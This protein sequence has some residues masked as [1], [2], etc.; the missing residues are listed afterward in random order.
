[1]RFDLDAAAQLPDALVLDRADSRGTYGPAVRTDGRVW[2]ATGS[3]ALL[4]G[5]DGNIESEITADP[6]KGWSRLT[7]ALDGRSFYL[8]NFLEG[9][10]QQRDATSGALILTHDIHRKYSLS[11]LAEVP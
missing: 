8:G 2:M 3:G 4:L 7:L 6:P 5:P 9:L 1:M 10:L 11:G